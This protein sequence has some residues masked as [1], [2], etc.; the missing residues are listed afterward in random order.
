M[1]HAIGSRAAEAPS[2]FA[3][4]SCNAPVDSIPGASHR[5]EIQ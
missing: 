5:V 3:L 4:N 2:A 1:L